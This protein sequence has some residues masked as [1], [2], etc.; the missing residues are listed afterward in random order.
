MIIFAKRTA[1]ISVSEVNF[2]DE[3][4]LKMGN[5]DVS[6]TLRAWPNRGVEEMAR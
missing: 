4:S 3:E 6:L 1:H 2:N 5:G